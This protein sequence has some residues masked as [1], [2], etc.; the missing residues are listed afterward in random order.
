M[1]IRATFAP[2]QLNFQISQNAV[3]TWYINVF[4]EQD[5]PASLGV[6]S[7][8]IYTIADMQGKVL[9]TK[10]LGDG[11]VV[12]G[13]VITVTVPDTDMFMTGTNTHQ[14][15]PV[16]RNGNRLSPI[17]KTPIYVTPTLR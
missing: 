9:V 17:F 1:G 4:N 14:L 8:F 15:V 7:N 16:D 13:S 5:N 3:A 11:V 2:T 10:E 12:T 6:F